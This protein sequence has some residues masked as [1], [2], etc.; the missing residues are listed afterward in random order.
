MGGCAWIEKGVGF[1]VV[2]P[3]SADELR[4]LAQEVQR[5]LDTRA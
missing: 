2:A 3:V 4:R 5:L 1:T